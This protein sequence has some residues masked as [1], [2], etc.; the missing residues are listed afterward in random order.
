M[1]HRIRWENKT[2][3]DMCTLNYLQAMNTHPGFALF[4]FLAYQRHITMETWK[5]PFF[6]R[7]DLN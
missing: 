7:E 2:F 3:D 6:T 1:K 5:H 4:S